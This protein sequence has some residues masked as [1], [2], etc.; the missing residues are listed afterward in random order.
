[1]R[2]IRPFQYGVDVSLI[3]AASQIQQPVVLGQSCLGRPRLRLVV[4]ICAGG[5]A[6]K[7]T[8][9]ALPLIRK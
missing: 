2:S 7:V 1:M 3:Y 8:D 4:I 5:G 9:N 6:L